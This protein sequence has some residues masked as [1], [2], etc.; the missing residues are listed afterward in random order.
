M[1][2]RVWCKALRRRIRSEVKGS[3]AL[4]KR[5]KAERKDLMRRTRD[6]SPVVWRSLILAGWVAVSLTQPEYVLATLMKLL[7]LW[8][9]FLLMTRWYSLGSVP[10]SIHGVAHLP[11]TPAD[12]FSYHWR[13]DWWR[14]AFLALE[15]AAVTGA[16]L[17]AHGYGAAGWFFGGALGAL[18]AAATFA[19][20]AA[21]AGQGWTALPKAFFLSAPVSFLVVIV[22]HNLFPKLA[23]SLLDGLSAVLLW[24]TPLG[25]VLQGT[26]ALG[27]QEFARAFC[28]LGATAA[29]AGTAFI[30]RA[31]L[32]RQTNFLDHLLA[33]GPSTSDGFDGETLPAAAPPP[34]ADADMAEETVE[35]LRGGALM[36]DAVGFDPMARGL[37]R[38]ISPQGRLLLRVLTGGWTDW[39]Q[40]W[41]RTLVFSGAGLFILLA[42]NSLVPGIRLQLFGAWLLLLYCRLPLL[43]G[44]WRALEGSAGAMRFS[45]VYASLPV[46]DWKLAT[47]IFTVNSVRFAALAPIIILPMAAAAAQIGYSFGGSLARIAT[48]FFLLWLAQPVV[49]AMRFSHTAKLRGGFLFLLMIVGVIIAFIAGFSIFFLMLEWASFPKVMPW[50]LGWYAGLYAIGGLYFWRHARGRVD[51][52][53]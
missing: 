14:S 44:S 11:V 2:D 40:H 19:A 42:V 46:S 20:G 4:H 45:P 37:V 7:P 28:L 1:R 24:L 12:Y 13:R 36:E 25:W 6:T 39:L 21:C 29:F 41:M 10:R 49:I 53:Q 23:A 3:P 30:S 50:I 27:R 33:P 38:C 52:V 32:L 31:Q 5:W 48:G 9:L 35:R 15:A 16:W 43:G 18:A 47:T 8:G 17:A 22:L 34:E 51:L 26:D